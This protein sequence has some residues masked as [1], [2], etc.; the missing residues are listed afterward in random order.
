MARPPAM[1]VFPATTT[2][3]KF[4]SGLRKFTFGLISMATTMEM[5]VSW[6]ANQGSGVSFPACR[7]IQSQQTSEVETQRLV[8]RP[9]G[10]S[11]NFREESLTGSSHL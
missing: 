11:Q 9:I 4:A 10:R 6:A 8:A 7:G 2:R 3:A 5:A 1:A